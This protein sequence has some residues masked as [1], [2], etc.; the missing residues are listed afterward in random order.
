MV[1]LILVD[2]KLIWPP[3][4][5]IRANEH[6]LVFVA[7]DGSVSALSQKCSFRSKNAGQGSNEVVHN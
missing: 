1:N 6:N 4:V 5:D 2:L 3:D 7:V